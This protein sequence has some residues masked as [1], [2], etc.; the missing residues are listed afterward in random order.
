VLFALLFNYAVMPIWTRHDAFVAVPDIREMQA[1]DA[2]RT[3]RLAG[4][5][6]ELQ[7]QPYNPNLDRDVV[8][9]QSPAAGTT[10]KPGRRIYFYINASPKEMA[11]VPDVVSLSEGKARPEITDAGLVVGRVELDSIRTPYENTVT[12]QV[13]VSGRQVPQGTRVTLWLSR[14]IDNSRQVRVPDVVGLS[15]ELARQRIRQASL[16][17][18]SPRA[19]GDRVESQEPAAGSLLH[20][21]QEILIRTTAARATPAPAELPTPESPTDPSDVA[22]EPAEPAAGADT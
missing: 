13:P 19:T 5:D 3:L 20:P 17:V 21:G 14:G 18:S 6:A 15:P 16:Y 1:A 2:E 8:V 12:R 4:L 10:V 22:P 11:I 7:E 9:D